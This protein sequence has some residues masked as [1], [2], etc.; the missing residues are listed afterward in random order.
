MPDQVVVIQKSKLSTILTL[1]GF[2]IVVGFVIIAYL[3]FRDMEIENEKLKNEVVQFQEITESLV[4]SSNRWVSKDDLKTAVSSLLTKGDLDG[5]KKDL[6]TQNARLSAVGRTVGVLARRVGRL[7][8]SDRQ[9]KE[10]ADVETCDDG[11]L[12]DTHG[13]TKHSQI[14]LL[15]DTNLAPLAEVEFDASKSKPWSYSIFERQFHLTTVVGKKESGQNVYYQSL[16]Y[17]V[18]NK[19]DKEYNIKLTSSEFKQA[20]LTNRMFWFNPKLDTNFLIG[21]R[22]W[23]FGNGWGGRTSSILSMG[24]DLGVS[25]SSYGMT[26][27][28]SEFRLFRFGLGYNAERQALHLSFAPITLNVAKYLPLLTNLYLGPQ[29]GID[30]AGGLTVNL[31]VGFQL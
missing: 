22:V 3:K 23:S 17:K 5:I 14:K 24:L 20:A 25:L 2:L 31:G 29:V 8:A 27:V 9:G 18:P 6:R 21:G 13:Y 7:E 4:R 15:T 11:R 12:V 19:G 30:S 1:V 26:E 28:D 16:K 10:N